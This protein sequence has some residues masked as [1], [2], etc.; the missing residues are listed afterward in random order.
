V[1]TRKRGRGRLM[2]RLGAVANWLAD[3]LDLLS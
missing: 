2:T 1:W 3:L